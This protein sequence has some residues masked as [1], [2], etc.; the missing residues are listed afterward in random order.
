MSEKT[1]KRTPV[2]VITGI[3]LVSKGIT[4]H[5]Q[6]NLPTL[7]AGGNSRFTG[8]GVKGAPKRA[9]SESESSNVK[10]L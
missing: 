10:K 4:E 5:T 7:T 6:S 9:V 2:P 3:R 8:E 1:K